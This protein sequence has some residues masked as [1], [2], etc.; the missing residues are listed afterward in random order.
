MTDVTFFPSKI[1][2]L[3]GLKSFRGLIFNVSQTD[4]TMEELMNEYLVAP[5]SINAF[6]LIPET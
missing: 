6:N 1:F 3:L 4:C 5:V 2:N